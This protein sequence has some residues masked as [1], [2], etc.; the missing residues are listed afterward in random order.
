[1]LSKIKT[2]L[3]SLLRNFMRSRIYTV[4]SGLAKGLKRK[5][6]LGFISRADNLEEQFLTSLTYQ[7]KNVYDIGCWEGI[8]TI[9]FAHAVGKEG[10]VIAFEP[11]P[12]NCTIIDDNIN[13]NGFTNVVLRQ[14]GLGNRNYSA[15]L[16][17]PK[18]STAEGSVNE[19]IANANIRSVATKVVEIDIDTLDNQLKKNQLPKPDFIKIDVEGMEKEVIEG[20]LRT[21]I[22]IKPDLFI[23]MHA[24]DS[25]KKQENAVKIVNLLLD[26]GYAIYHIESGQ[27][28]DISNAHDAAVGHIY[29]T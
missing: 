29:C 22:E 13:L 10:N 21:I 5:G 3:L 14:V 28:I 8:T 17:V 9:Y 24:A 1:M 23:E 12:D 11:N 20:M 19:D 15:R 6:G 18:H 27:R 26:H 4:K 7:G 25:R 16:V 2:M